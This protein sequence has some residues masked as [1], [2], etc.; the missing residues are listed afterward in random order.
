MGPSEQTIEARL[1]ALRRR[2]EA[3]DREIADLLLYLELGRRLSGVEAPPTDDTPPTARGIAADPSAGDDRGRPQPAARGADMAGRDLPSLTPPQDR[4]PRDHA[5]AA[6]APADPPPAPDAAR[7]RAGDGPIPPAVAFAEDPTAARRY[8]RALVA[9]ACAV[10]AQAGRPL[11][12]GEILERLVAR[13]FSVPGRDPVAALNTRLWKRATP[14]GP[15]RR[16]GEARYGLAGARDG[17]T[18]S[19]DPGFGAGQG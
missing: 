15:L 17:D 8:G 9:A 14:E 1:S 7:K 19:G 12:A 5:P 11:H 4:P 13:G 16:L 6:S 18:G 10:I 2:R 3:I